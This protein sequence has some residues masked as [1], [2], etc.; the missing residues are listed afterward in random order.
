MA[1]KWFYEGVIPEDTA[2]F[3]LAKR[4]Y[5]ACAARSRA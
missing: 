4:T 2:M 1:A 3:R 5:Y